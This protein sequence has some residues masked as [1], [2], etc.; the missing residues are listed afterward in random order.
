MI[1][2]APLYVLIA[3][4]WGLFDQTATSWVLQAKK[5]DRVL[6]LGNS[7]HW[8][9][10]PSQL[11]A[12]N[13]MLVM[14]FIPLFSYGVY[15][16]V[17]RVAAVTPLRKIA[18]GLFVTAAAFAVPAWVESRITAGATPHIVW[19]LAAYVLI[20]AAEI[21]V[22]ITVLEFSYTQ[23]PKKMKSFI[24]SLYLLSI[25]LG[26]QFTALV[27]RFIQ[28]DDGTSKLPGADY[29]WFFTI[30]MLATAVVFVLWSQFYHGRTYIQGDDQH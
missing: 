11:Q 22:S 12:I 16:L 25:S 21:M 8:E 30:A 29:Y 19:H 10:L 7:V 26:N 5:M 6:W 1:N 27:N 17:G 20:T 18:V 14:I 13:P 9:V 15:P 28:N 23:A 24:M 3:P 2:L 4:F